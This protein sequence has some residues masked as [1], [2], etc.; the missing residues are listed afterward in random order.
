MCLYF[1]SG[2]H[3]EG[4]GQTECANQILEQYLQIYCNYQ[5]DNWLEL[6]PL[7]EFSYNNMPS[8]TMGISP[9]FTNKGYHPNF[10]VYSDCKL[11]SSSTKSY[12][13]DKLHD[14]L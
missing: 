1:T 3:P 2:Y 14:L 9:F 6:L 11:T 13:L 7:A 8:A 12:V 5:Q 10:S 4:D